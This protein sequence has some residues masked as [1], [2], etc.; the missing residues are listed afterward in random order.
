MSGHERALGLAAAKE[1]YV[2]EW[3]SEKVFRINKE[4]KFE[5]LGELKAGYLAAGSHLYATKYSTGTIYK[6]EKDMWQI[7]NKDKTA[8]SIAVG[9]Y[10]RV[11]IVDKSSM[12]VFHQIFD[13]KEV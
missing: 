9:R 6:L 3:S 12:K 10:N 7:A 13:E 5:G 11:Y 2:R 1:V 4:K 8:Y